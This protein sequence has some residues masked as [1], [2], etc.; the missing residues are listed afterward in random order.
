MF[1][2]NGFTVSDR[3]PLYIGAA[4]ELSTGKLVVAASTRW[5]KIELDGKMFARNALFPFDEM[6]MSCV[7]CA[8]VESVTTNSGV[9]V[10]CPPISALVMLPVAA[11]SDIPSGNGGKLALVLTENV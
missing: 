8:F 3:Y 9:Y 2:K 10:P 1:P 6:L 4:G 5:W 7:A 11:S